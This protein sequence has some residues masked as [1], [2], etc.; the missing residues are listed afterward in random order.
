MEHQG[1]EKTA[2][3]W[4]TCWFCKNLPADPQSGIEMEMYKMSKIPEPKITSQGIE[5]TWWLREMRE[6]VAVPRCSKCKTFHKSHGGL[7]STE[8]W[9]L[10]RLVA[11]GIVLVLFASFKYGMEATRDVAIV[12]FVVGMMVM[13]V[14]TEVAERIRPERIKG[15]SH[16]SDFPVIQTRKAEGWEFREL[17]PGMKEKRAAPPL[18]AADV[19]LDEIVD[20]LVAIYRQHPE[21][22]IVDS[23]GGEEAE[24]RRIGGILNE[25]GGM[26][27][28]RAVHAQFAARCGVFGAPRNLEHMWGGIG[29][30]QG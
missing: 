7:G 12:A 10:L 14:A 21:G 4:H 5:T 15:E 22:F 11:V 26:E 19:S 29:R 25:R 30:W 8:F 24:I 20:R 28:M 1:A 3:L 17:P 9:V 16:K 2:L 23:G 27:L 13:K 18:L 6:A